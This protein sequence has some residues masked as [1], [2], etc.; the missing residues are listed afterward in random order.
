MSDASILAN[1]YS[2]DQDG[3][4]LVN[5]TNVS[6]A[7]EE[8]SNELQTCGTDEFQDIYFN[9]EV[10]IKFEIIENYTLQITLADTSNTIVN[11]DYW[12]F[13][14]YII[15]RDLFERLNI[16]FSYAY[17]DFFNQNMTFYFQSDSISLNALKDGL[18]LDN[19]KLELDPICLEQPSTP[20]SPDNT[21]TEPE[22]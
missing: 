8:L 19:V 16:N 15:L 10:D 1:L 18:H 9:K 3:S 20:S 17:H 21:D 12:N 7:L 14:T 4:I 6:K 22:L 11:A 13:R 5:K 2:F